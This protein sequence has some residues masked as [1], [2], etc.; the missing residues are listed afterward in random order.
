MSPLDTTVD[1]STYFRGVPLLRGQRCAEEA[2]DQ[3]GS[4]PEKPSS[5]WCHVSRVAQRPTS[6]SGKVLKITLLVIALAAGGLAGCRSRPAVRGGVPEPTETPNVTLPLNQ[7]F[8]LEAW[9][10]PPVDTTVVFTPGATRTVL[11]RHAPP[12]N[13]IFAELTLPDSL[14]PGS[15]TDSVRLQLEP[16]PG[17]YGLTITCLPTFPGGAI[18]TFKYPVHFAAPAPALQRYG[19]PAMFERALGIGVQQPDGRFRLLPSTRPAA[20]N[21]S[22]TIPGPGVYVVAAPR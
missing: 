6:S 4:D 17:V 14:F 18:L 10:A 16:R 13:T 5:L 9:G 19:N 2:R 12:D 15:T 1:E 21:L 3:S 20:D 22:A 11:L 7:F 8:V